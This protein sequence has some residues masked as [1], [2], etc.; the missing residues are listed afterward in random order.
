MCIFVV[1][2]K[3]ISSMGKKKEKE[4]KRNWELGER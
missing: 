4:N 2:K 3:M 1:Y